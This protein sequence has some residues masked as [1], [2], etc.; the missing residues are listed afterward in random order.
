[1]SLISRLNLALPDGIRS[2]LLRR[3]NRRRFPGVQFDGDVHVTNSRIE[4][5]AQLQDG[6]WVTNAAIGAYTY[7]TRGCYINDASIG[8]FCSIACDVWVGTGVHPS[9][10]YAST[11]PAFHL[12]AG[13][14]PY[15]FV[16]RDRFGAYERTTVGNDVWIGLRA[17][18]LGGVTVGDGAIIGA[19]A[20]VTKD[21]PPYAVVGG[22]P[23]RIL[24]Y[25]FDETT[26]A[27]LQRL[28]WWDKDATWLRH[29]APAF[30]DAHRLLAEASA[31]QT[32]G[33]PNAD[34]PIDDGSA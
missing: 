12:A 5:P 6:V 28:K 14:L 9:R 18:V 23:A 2:G 30:E 24:R 29:H 33:E 25:R 26:I 4:A 20:L 3:E 15:S 22:V 1:M 16:D 7:V 34:R 21:V 27:G 19:S 17:I 13:P 11:H 8:R 10:G 31:E 32:H